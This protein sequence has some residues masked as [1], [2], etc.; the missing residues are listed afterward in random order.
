VL[1]LH[2]RGELANPACPI[3]EGNHAGSHL[4]VGSLG[5]NHHLRATT[6]VTNAVTTTAAAAAAAAALR[7]RRR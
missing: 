2:R 5:M 1:A 4:V 6:T 7:W 3:L